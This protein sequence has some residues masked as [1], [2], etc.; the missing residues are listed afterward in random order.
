MLK[1]NIIFINED[2]ISVDHCI[3]LQYLNFV[4]S[5]LFLFINIFFLNEYMFII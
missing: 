5:A 1:N 4:L 2:S 3:I